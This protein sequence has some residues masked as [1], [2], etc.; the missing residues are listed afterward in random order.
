MDMQNMDMEHLSSNTANIENTALLILKAFKTSGTQAD[1][2]L[3]WAEIYPFL[4]KADDHE[5]FRDVQKLAEEHLRNQSYAI[6]DPAGLRLTEV[7]YKAI[8]EMD[9]QDLSQS[10]AR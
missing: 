8:Q 2:V 6:P 1:E 4:N 10:N 3:P 5:H 7:G 9:G